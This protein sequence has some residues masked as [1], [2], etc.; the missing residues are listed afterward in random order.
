M[1]NNEA[2]RHLIYF[3]VTDHIYLEW[4]SQYLNSFDHRLH[5]KYE[6]YS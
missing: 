1:S 2:S 3:H 4:K 6:N 5:V